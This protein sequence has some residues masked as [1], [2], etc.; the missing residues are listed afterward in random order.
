M[1][2]SNYTFSGLIT[3][4]YKVLINEINDCLKKWIGTHSRVNISTFPR[5]IYEFNTI[6]IEIQE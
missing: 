1:C 4:N 5:L 3:K 6:I 2:K